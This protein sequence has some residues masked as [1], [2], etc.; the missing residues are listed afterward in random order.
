MGGQTTFRVKDANVSESMKDAF[1][2]VD[3]Y[4]GAMAQKTNWLY[5][6]RA[7]VIVPNIVDTNFRMG[8]GWDIEGKLFSKLPEWDWSEHGIEPVVQTTLPED[9]DENEKAIVKSASNALALSTMPEDG[10]EDEK[11]IVK[12]ASNAQT[13]STMPENGGENTQTIEVNTDSQ[14]ETPYILLAFDQ[15]VT[16][17]KIKDELTIEREGVEIDINWVGDDGEIDPDNEINAD[18][19]ILKNNDGESYRVTLLRLKEDGTYQVNTGSLPLETD[20]SKGVAITPFEEMNLDLKEN[21]ISGEIKYAEKGTKYVLRTY[22]A[23]DS[24]GADY[25]VDEQVVDDPSGI[26]ID[27]PTEGTLVPTGNYYVTSFLMVEKEA[28]LDDD[29]EPEKALAAIDSQKF[30]GTIAYKNTSQPPAPENVSLKAIGNEAMK[31]SWEKMDGVSGYRVTI[32]QQDGSEWINTGFGYDLDMDVT[33]VDMALTVGGNAVSV[34]GNSATSVP[35]ENLSADEAYKVGVSAYNETEEG[36]KY[37]SAETESSGEYLPEYKPLFMTVSVNG[38]KCTTDENGVYHAYVGSGSNSISVDCADAD[39]ITVTRMDTDIPLAEDET[40]ENT[41]AIPEFT[42][43]LML[44][45]D[46]MKGEDVTSVFLLVSMDGTSPMLVL[47]DPIFYAD[48]DSGAYTITGTAD[49]GSRILYGDAGKSVYA[50]AD[51]SFVINGNLDERESSDSLYLRAQDSAGNLSA[52]QL[53]LVARQVA[54][55]SVIVKTDGNGTASAVPSTAAAGTGITLTATPNRGYRFKEWQVISG[56]VTIADNEFTM[57]DE[58]VEIKAIFE[59]DTPPAPT[60]YTVTFD[61]N[62][63]TPSVGSMTTIGQKLSSLPEASRRGS[64]SFDGWYTEKIGGIKVTTATIFPANTTVY[65]RWAYTGG[66]DGDDDSDES[67]A[68]GGK[69]NSPGTSLPDYVV[70]GGTW[71]QDNAGRWFF[72]TDRTY[73]DEW[74]AILNPYADTSRG[75]SRFDWFHFGKD[76]AMTTGW[77]NDERGDTFYLNP[78]SDNTLGRMFTGWNWID[79]NGDG[80][81]ECYYFQEA[82]DGR[83]GRLYKKTTTPDGYTVNEKGQWTV[84]GVVQTKK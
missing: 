16:E 47:S 23:K 52:Q 68:L 21:Q 2:N 24:G 48:T 3:I 82:S 73:T 65:A 19:D 1:K 55:Y 64:Y 34:N 26:S 9:G 63:G 13:L 20:K 49:A 84:D 69:E 38:T 15:S 80:V 42:G 14:D 58:N 60:E 77:Y 40:G 57:P 72:S 28:D 46:G 79:D 74:G 53:A 37:Y 76:S 59:E 43:T 22:L 33:S 11:A 25:L 32:Y 67:S 27:I 7:W 61:G 78:V 56:G 51:G 17:E 29:G 50:S 4:L 83:R 41:F 70:R 30:E 5:D 81:S 31:A 35:A 36:A 45:V 39:R 18:I 10:D 8:E 75:Q 71:F 66:D 12:S 62:G 6:V 44:R 54:K